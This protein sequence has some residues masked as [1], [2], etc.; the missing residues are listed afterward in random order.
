MQPLPA[1]KAAKKKV[2]LY[3]LILKQLHTLRF[4][5]SPYSDSPPNFQSGRKKKVGTSAWKL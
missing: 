1:F 3:W 5:I 2:A 4:N